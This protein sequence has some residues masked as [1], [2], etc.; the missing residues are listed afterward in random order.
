MK[1]R[2][3]IQNANQPDPYIFKDGDKFYMY[4]TADKGVEAYSSDDIFGTWQFEGIVMTIDNCYEFWAPCI[5]KVGEWYHIYVSCSSENMFEHLHTAR[6]KSPLGPFLEPK[7]LY[8]RFSI[9]AHVVE[10]KEGQR[11]MLLVILKILNQ[12]FNHVLHLRKNLKNILY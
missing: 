5:I 6:S 12:R 3:D 8:N 9:D 2:F 4:V 7:M 11:K 10:T 1:L